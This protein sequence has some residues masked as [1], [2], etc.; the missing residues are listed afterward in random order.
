MYKRRVSKIYQF[1]KELLQWTLT[2]AYKGSTR[3]GGTA[4]RLQQCRRLS[5][6]GNEISHCVSAAGDNAALKSCQFTCFVVLCPLRRQ[7]SV[8]S[9]RVSA[10]RVIRLIVHFTT[11]TPLRLIGCA[12]VVVPFHREICILGRELRPLWPFPGQI[13][14]WEI[15]SKL[16]VVECLTFIQP[17]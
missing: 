5:E 10:L 8:R 1:V 4:E 15:V 7:H 9:A 16:F 3:W 11:W 17:V 6:L 13:M 14:N 2:H 12:R